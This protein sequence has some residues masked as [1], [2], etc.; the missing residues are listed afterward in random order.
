MTFFQPIRDI[1]VKST[2]NINILKSEDPKWGVSERLYSTFK[3]INED[4]LILSYF[5]N[6]IISIGIVKKINLNLQ[7][8]I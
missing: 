3:K 8:I 4:D 7:I 2:Y 5:K 1:S 6:N